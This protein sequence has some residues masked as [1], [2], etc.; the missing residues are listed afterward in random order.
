MKPLFATA[1]IF[2]AQLATAGFAT[3]QDLSGSY[4]VAG[5]N[6]NGSPYGGEA[7]ISLTSDYTCGIV[8]TTGSSSSSGICMRSGNAFAAGYELNGKVGLVIYLIES[9]GTLNGTWTVA[10]L[11]AAGTEVLTPKR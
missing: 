3:A 10:G 5:T 8:W 6:L 7:V 11:N 9:D 1:F 2:T 4:S